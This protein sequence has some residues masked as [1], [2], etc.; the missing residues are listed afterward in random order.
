[1]DCFSAYRVAKDSFS[2]HRVANHKGAK[3]QTV[4]K[5]TKLPCSH[6]CQ[7]KKV[8]KYTHT[9]QPSTQI[10]SA[11]TIAKHIVHNC[12]AYKVAKRAK[13]HVRDMVVKN[14]EL[15]RT[16]KPGSYFLRMRM[17]SEF[18]VTPSFRSEYRKGVEQSSTAANC[19]LRICDVKIRFAFAFAGI[20]NRALDSAVSIML[21]TKCACRKSRLC[22]SFVN[23]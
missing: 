4:A 8:A 11:H 5:H 3:K 1:M 23:M 15:L 19:S 17:R 18:D 22:G 16:L 13:L 20:M 7:V 9:F 21:C 10:C 6:S 2:A 12:Q 14:T